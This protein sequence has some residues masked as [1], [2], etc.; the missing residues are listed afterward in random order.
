MLHMG[1][2]KAFEWLSMIKQKLPSYVHY[3][4][5]SLVQ[6]TARHYKCHKIYT[7]LISG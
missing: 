1:S 2:L 5:Q 6:S 4:L 7:N 3:N